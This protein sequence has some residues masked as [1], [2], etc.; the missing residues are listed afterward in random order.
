MTASAPDAAASPVLPE[1]E[2][3]PEAELGHEYDGPELHP[4]TPEYADTYAEYQD[5]IAEAGAENEAVP[6]TLTP[7][8]EAALDAAEPEPEAGL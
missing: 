4:G 3:G 8:A 5:W 6:Y 1:P 7:Q 2:A